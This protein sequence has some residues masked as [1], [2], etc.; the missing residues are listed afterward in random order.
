MTV[1]TDAP[2]GLTSV[3]SVVS[4]SS[5]FGSVKHT[6]PRPSSCVFLDPPNLCCLRWFL[7]HHRQWVWPSGT[8]GRASQDIYPSP[9]LTY[10]LSFSPPRGIGS[11][12][13]RR[14][15]QH[16]PSTPPHH[17][18]GHDV[19]NSIQEGFLPQMKYTIES[20][21][22]LPYAECV[23][24]SSFSKTRYRARW[25][26]PLL[27]LSVESLTRIIPFGP[28]SNELRLFALPLSYTCIYATLH[29]RPPTS[30]IMCIVGV[31]FHPRVSPPASIGLLSV[32][33]KGQFHTLRTT[34]LS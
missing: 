4:P 12:I 2:P 30:C 22:T 24:Y 20:F 14:A 34:P 26:L 31:I 27:F 33:A 18:H 7:D 13:S 23:S 16:L 28:V 11:G 21:N 5:T 3:R 32:T 9:P 15:P 1:D 8:C 10:E 6:S 17:L 25:Q 19:P 29:N